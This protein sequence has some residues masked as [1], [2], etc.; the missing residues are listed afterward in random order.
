MWRSLRHPNILPLLGVTM[1]ET[2]LVM[3][4][5]WMMNGNINEFMKA[6]ADAD[7]LGLVSTKFSIRPHILFDHRSTLIAER[8]RWGRGIPTHPGSGPRG[9]QG[10]TSSNSK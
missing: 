1:N 2:Q 5:E 8:R 9:S 6:H 4:S 10:G 7:R 3:A